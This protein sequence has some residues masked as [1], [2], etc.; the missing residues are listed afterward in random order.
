MVWLVHLEGSARPISG[1][2]SKVLVEGV[3]GLV[4]FEDK[5]GVFPEVVV[6]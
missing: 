6:A 4:K 3:P 1:I 5:L 2:A